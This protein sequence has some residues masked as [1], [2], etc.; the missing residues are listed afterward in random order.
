MDKTQ[1]FN[2]V[3]ARTEE[4]FYHELSDCAC[5]KT[6]FIGVDFIQSKNIQGS[7]PEEIIE[8]SIREIVAAGFTEKISYSIRG[9]DILLYVK[10]KGC[11]HMPKEVILK[12]RGIKPYNCP[13]INMILDQLIEKLNF[14]TTY[15]ADVEIDENSNECVLKCGIFETPEKIGNVCD[16]SSECQ[17]VDEQDEWKTVICDA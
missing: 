15:V 12:K 5:W 16:W 17:L 8:N 6:E 7:T 13:I 3:M 11:L 14:E 1:Y 2:E 10:I 4:L 9:N